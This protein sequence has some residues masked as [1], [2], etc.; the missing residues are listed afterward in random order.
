MP[1]MELEAKNV[2]QAIQKACEQLKISR[3]NL[4]YS[5][6]S[7]GSTGI[8]GLGRTKKARI[9]VNLTDNNPETVTETNDIEQT[10]LNNDGDVKRHVQ[11]L[12]Q[13]TF[14]PALTST[15]TFPDTPRDLGLDVLQRIIDSI[16]SDARIVVD[17]EP[18]RILFKVRGGNS[19]VLIGKHGQTLEAIQ[20]LVEKIVNKHNSE[21]I[22]VH[23]D[24][25]GYL[26][27]RKNN[28]I[29]QAERLAQKCKKIKKPVTVGYMNAYDRRIVHLALKNDNEVSTQSL[30]EGLLR[31]LMI[32][33]KKNSYQ[34]RRNR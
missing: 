26:E 17:E 11:S 13:N 3:D 32:F 1:T 25:E 24:V 34:R 5:V 29:L 30:G 18:E 4:K 15:P 16:T 2:E 10:Q 7:Y 31:K 19:A 9:R 12:I 6:I 21:R 14:S 20:S 28:L 8:F 23:V 33:P 27:N 22:R